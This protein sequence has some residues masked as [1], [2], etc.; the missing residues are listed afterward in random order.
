MEDLGLGTTVGTCVVFTE[1]GL[2]FGFRSRLQKILWSMISLSGNE[3]E[4]LKNRRMQ[5]D[6]TLTVLSASLMG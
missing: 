3:R 2:A 4:R 1:R 5:E 6:V